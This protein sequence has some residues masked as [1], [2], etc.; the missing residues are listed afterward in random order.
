MLQGTWITGLAAAAP[1]LKAGAGGDT[2]GTR[3]NWA[4]IYAPPGKPTS[5]SPTGWDRSEPSG[6]RGPLHPRAVGSLSHRIVGIRIHTYPVLCKTHTGRWKG[7]RPSDLASSQ[8]CWWCSQSVSPQK[9]WR[10]HKRWRW[11]PWWNALPPDIPTYP[12]HPKDREGLRTPG[13]PEPPLP[14]SPADGLPILISGDCMAYDARKS[15]RH[16]DDP[17]GGTVP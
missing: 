15:G 6:D 12:G 8:I 14:G 7:P 17:A 4:A 13:V 9:T 11:R 2:S 16:G 5:R 1:V 10:S 3:P